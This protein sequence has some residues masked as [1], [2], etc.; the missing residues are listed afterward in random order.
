MATPRILDGK[1]RVH[2]PTVPSSGLVR[3]AVLS[4]S[5]TGQHPRVRTELSILGPTTKESGRSPLLLLLQLDDP[6]PIG[7]T[8]MH[9]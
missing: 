5:W 6:E 1:G 2:L 4:K 9:N 7:R 8:Q 3:T